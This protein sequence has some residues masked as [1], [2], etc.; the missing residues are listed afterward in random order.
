MMGRICQYPLCLWASLKG[1]SRDQLNSWTT[2]TRL[3]D[4]LDR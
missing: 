4:A 1:E 3:Q 2:G